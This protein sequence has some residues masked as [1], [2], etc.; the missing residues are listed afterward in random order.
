MELWKGL[1]VRHLEQTPR[2]RLCWSSRLL[3]EQHAIVPLPLPLGCCGH[4]RLS[5]Q[6]AHPSSLIMFLDADLRP[7][8]RYLCTGCMPDVHARS[9]YKQCIY[10]HPGRDWGCGQAYRKAA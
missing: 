1:V 6:A 2:L 9:V 3:P 5:P 7:E 8:V 10:W 4:R